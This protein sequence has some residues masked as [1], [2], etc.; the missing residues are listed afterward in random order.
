MNAVVQL[1]TIIIIILQW[2]SLSVIT[3]T[4]AAN[5]KW[6]KVKWSITLAVVEH[7]AHEALPLGFSWHIDK[8]IVAVVC[9]QL[10]VHSSLK[11]HMVNTQPARNNK[12]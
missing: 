10:S 8:G 9:P 3:T 7:L 6:H 4:S 11:Q 5:T 1:T 12:K 2:V